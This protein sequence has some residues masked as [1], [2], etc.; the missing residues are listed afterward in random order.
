MRTFIRFRS[1]LSI[2]F[3]ISCLLIVNN[4]CDKKSPP[5]EPD[6]ELTHELII[7]GYQGTLVA[8]NIDSLPYIDLVPGTY[9]VSV[10]G[11]GIKLWWKQEVAFKYLILW[12]GNAT[13]HHLVRSGNPIQ[14]T[15]TQQPFTKIFAFLIDVNNVDSSGELDV[16]F[17]NGNENKNLHV[18]GKIGTLVVDIDPMPSIDL[19]PGT[20]DVTISGA[21]I[22]LWWQQS[23]PFKY[24][25]LWEGNATGHHLIRAGEHSQISLT[26]QPFTR[27]FGFVIDVNNIDSSGNLIVQFKQ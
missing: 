13:G 20:Y 19:E 5:T 26:Q 18:D 23:D 7:D 11:T 8:K 9:T 17:S 22:K 12:E 14:I 25:L 2:F 21:G 6:E 1:V 15:V 4:S 24:A 3:V 27:V 16:Q 10:S